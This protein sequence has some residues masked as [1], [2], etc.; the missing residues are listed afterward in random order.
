VGRAHVANFIEPT[1]CHEF[2]TKAKWEQIHSIPLENSQNCCNWP[3]FRVHGR[4]KQPNIKT[5][6]EDRSRG[7]KT[8][9]MSDF[10]R[11]PGHDTDDGWELVYGIENWNTDRTSDT[12]INSYAD[13]ITAVETLDREFLKLEGA[14]SS[15]GK[16]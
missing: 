2:L 4:T 9:K 12:S 16:E 14:G 5:W 3:E 1:W 7:K 15:E 13:A 11:N 10:D 8:N 6:W